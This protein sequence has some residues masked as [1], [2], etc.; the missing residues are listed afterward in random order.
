MQGAV[1]RALPQP[2][3]ADLWLVE[4]GPQRVLGL[5]IPLRMTVLRLAGGGLWL[6]SPVPYGADLASALQAIG[7]VRHLVAPGTAHWTHLPGWQAAFPV[8]RLWAAPGVVARAARQGVALRAHGVLGPVPAPDWAGQIDQAMLEGLGFVEIAFHHR[9][10]GS[11]ILTDTVQAMAPAQLPR[12][13]GWLPRLLGAAAPD[14]GTPLHVRLLLL[15]HRR[16]NRA[17]LQRLLELAPRR[18]IFAHGAWFAEDGA[19]RL[20]RAFAWLM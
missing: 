18:V 9:A 5:P 8:A 14:G 19:A 13:L 3:A 17:A 2:I 4:G 16:R 10:S 11:L 7:P 15:R 1:H 6:H 12:G 20:R